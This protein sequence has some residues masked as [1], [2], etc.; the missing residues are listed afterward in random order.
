MVR[1]IGQRLDINSCWWE[2]C[3]KDTCVKDPWARGPVPQIIGACKLPQHPLHR[4][5]LGRASG[6][7]VAFR[8]II[9]KIPVSLEDSLEPP[10][11]Q[12]ERLSQL[13]VHPQPPTGG[14]SE[15]G[16]FFL[17]PFPRPLPFS[18]FSSMFEEERDGS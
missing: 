8:S 6:T 10:R 1:E 15:T 14:T 16:L 18:V 7:S 4:I 2:Q 11:G 17:G 12:E 13:Q 3:K 5:H 9:S